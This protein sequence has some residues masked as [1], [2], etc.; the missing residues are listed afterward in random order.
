VTT[1]GEYWVRIT[2]ENNCV[3]RCNIELEPCAP[4]RM[5][6]GSNDGQIPPKGY[7]DGDGGSANAQ[8]WTTGGQVGAPSLEDPG[9]YGEWT[10]RE[11]GKDVS[12]FTFHAGTRSAPDGTEISWVQCYDPCNCSPAR[13]APAKQIDFYGIGSIKNGELAG[14]GKDTLMSFYVH[15]EDLGEPGNKNLTNADDPDQCP[16]M[17]RDGDPAS[18]DCA[19]FYHIQIWDNLSMSGASVYEAYGYIHGGNFQIH[20]PVGET[21]DGSGCEY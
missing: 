3:S 2:D 5:T 15:V 9:P 18:C 20:P 12:N 8:A 10:H 19:D 17:G 14:N 1:A 7:A 21:F 13:P 11:H 16:D 4:C 6:G